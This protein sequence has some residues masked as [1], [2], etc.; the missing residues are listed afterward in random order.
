MEVLSA[1]VNRPLAL[2][3]QPIDTTNDGL[4]LLVL[5]PGAGSEPIRCKL[6]FSTFAERPSY[7]ALSYT[8]GDPGDTKYIEIDGF[9][10]QIGKNLWTALHNLRHRSHSQTLW[11][12]SICI[13]QSS[14]EEKSH[15][16]P[17]MAFIYGRAERV[18][19]WLGRHQEH[20]AAC[21]L[22]AFSSVGLSRAEPNYDISAWNPCW[23]SVGP[24][25][26]RLIHEEYWKRTWII[27]E[28]GM[29]SNIRVHFGEKSLPWDNFLALVK[30]Y[31]EENPSAQAVH[32]ILKL[33]RLRES[34]YRDGKTYAL[35]DLLDTFRNS[36]CAVV[37]DKIYAFLGL[38]NDHFGEISVNYSRTAFELY[39]DVI[40]FQSIST[41]ESTQKRVEIVYI[42]A[43]VRR[44]LSRE[45][46]LLP[47]E[48][49]RVIPDNFMTSHK[50]WTNWYLIEAGKAIARDEVRK[51][52]A[53]R[54]CENARRDD[55][56]KESEGN[57]ALGYLLL[58]MLFYPLVHSWI[59]VQDW[60]TILDI[61]SKTEY[62]MFWYPTAAENLEVWQPRVLG[63]GIDGI[64]I[65]GAIVGRVQYIGPLSDEILA[66]FN[67]KKRWAA[68]LS[69]QFSNETELRRVR[70][71]NERLMHILEDPSGITTRNIHDFHAEQQGQPQNALRLFLGTNGMAGIIPPG[72]KVGDTICQ[73]WNSSASAVLR[74]DIDG[75]YQVIGRAG[76]VQYGKRG[77][78]DVPEDKMMFDES[79]NSAVD[80]AVHI[81]TLTGLSLDTVNFQFST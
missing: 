25:I 45:S 59:A 64:Q 74:Q 81:M 76:I 44:M 29:A 58:Y 66:S 65:R 18:I 60:L 24:L 2:Q 78:W 75:V 17:I 1:C 9:R 26:Y 38:A 23:T 32:Y 14:A 6:Y 63:N 46:G 8:W 40:Q 19:V 28:I 73:F 21:D 41:L 3:Y 4:R 68:S 35:S 27:Q 33:G 49:K 7:S 80:L 42:S 56:D 39:Q 55:C 47:K 77:D 79:S 37:H 53:R 51:A 67:A 72:V 34:R 70:G 36:F 52:V 16:I 13:D 5:E 69:S 43:L 57:G 62:T 22:G 12:D 20:N 71:Q 31:Q 61:R 30:W 54:D 15:Q 10:I 50:T 11:V 48:L